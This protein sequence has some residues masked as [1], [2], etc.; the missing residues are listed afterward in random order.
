MVIEPAITYPLI[1]CFFTSTEIRQIDFVMSQL[2]CS[3]LGGLNR[4]FPRA[5]LH[6]PP[7]LGGMDIPSSKQKITSERINY[8]IYNIRHDS[9][10]SKNWKYP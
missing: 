2:K 6:G 10:I 8:F 7:E 3:A 9:S 5:V 4:N 1:T